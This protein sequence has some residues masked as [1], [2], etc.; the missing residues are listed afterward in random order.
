MTAAELTTACFAFA[1]EAGV[2][3]GRN[4]LTDLAR[5]NLF[6]HSWE[7]LFKKI[8]RRGLV[9]ERLYGWGPNAFD[10]DF[11]TLDVELGHR[12]A[13]PQKLSNLDEKLFGIGFPEQ[14]HGTTEGKGREAYVGG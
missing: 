6:L 4:G 7:Q 10:R 13:R 12:P 1:R 5:I 8:G 9:R 14:T 2:G 11:Q 3:G